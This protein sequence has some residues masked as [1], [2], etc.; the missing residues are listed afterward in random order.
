[1]TVDRKTQHQSPRLLWRLWQRTRHGGGS[2]RCCVQ[3]SAQQGN[4]RHDLRS[5]HLPGLGCS[6]YAKPCIVLKWCYS[7]S[8]GTS[9]IRT[10][11]D[12]TDSRQYTGAQ[13][14]N[15][16]MGIDH[17]STFSLRKTALIIRNLYSARSSKRITRRAIGLQSASHISRCRNEKNGLT[18]VRIIFLRR[19]TCLRYTVFTRCIFGKKHASLRRI[20]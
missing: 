14:Y 6:R 18:L 19:T 16:S 11:L 20:L 5:V 2:K 1:M 7:C 3:L 17:L 12:G 13:R 8:G 9:G 4:F 15:S 10:C